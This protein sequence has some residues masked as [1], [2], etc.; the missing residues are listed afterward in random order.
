M[1]PSVPG[2]PRRARG[3]LIQETEEESFGG[4]AETIIPDIPELA[5]Q[6]STW[7]ESGLTATYD[8]PGLRTI[9][10]N[11]TARRQKLPRLP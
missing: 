5:T 1:L 8:I 9:S 4:N 10:P 6:E 2:A 3:N 7:A 11:H